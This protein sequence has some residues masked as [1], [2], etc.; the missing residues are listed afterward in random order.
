MFK[1]TISLV[2]FCISIL[3]AG[4]KVPV[5]DLVYNDR[6]WFYKESNV[7]F[8]G[9]AFSI[10]K[11]TGTII[12]Q[13]NYIDGLAWGKYYEW[14]PNGSKKVNGTY[15]FGLMY[16]R[17]K[18][19]YESGKILCAGS[20][21]NG[22]GHN[23]TDLINNIPQDGI[24]GLWTYW[25]ND[26]R[27]VEEGYYSKNGMEKGNWAFWDRDGKK[28]I[29]K[30]IDYNTFKNIG[31]FKHLDGVFLVTGPLDGLTTVYTQAHGA[32]RSGKLDG[33]WTYW[34]NDGL[35]SAKKHYDKGIPWGQYTTYH[36]LGHKL[37][38]GIVKGLDDYRNL[39]KDGKWLFWDEQG[40]LKEEVHYKDGKREGLSTYFSI[41]GNQSAKIIYKD[42]IPWNGEWTIWYHDGTKKES[43][44]YSE[45]EKQS[46]WTAWYE[47][48]QKKYVIH[49]KNSLKHGLYTEWN[50][51]GR[52]TKDIEYNRGNPISEYLVEYQGQSY[53][54]INRRNG[55]LSGSWIKWYGNGKKCEEGVYKY[56]KKGGLWTGWH[57]NGEKKYNSK[58][59]DG[60]P[61]GLYT[62]L[63]NKG[64]LTKNIEYDQGIILSEYHISRDQS[65]ATEYHKKNGV[66]DGKWTR[67][68]SNGNKAEEG[69]YKNG[70]RSGNWNGWYRSNKKNYACIYEDGKRAGTYTEWNSKGKKI[71]EIDYSNGNRIREYVVIKDGSGF[72]EMS[73]L[74]GKLDG[75]W[76]KWYSDGKKEEEGKYKGGIK[77]GT[78]SRYSMEGAI[79][80]EW[81][82]DNKGRNLYEITYYDNGTV[83]EYRDFFSKT[84][85]EYNVDG[86]LKGDKI[87]FN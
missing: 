70:K 7:P 27:K 78:W 25:D 84:I 69:I 3:L 30:K 2:C 26:G 64:R 81:N 71:K 60:K 11:E 49:Y 51:D 56:G 34:N 63:D 4:L 32:I 38:D 24:S 35:L 45:G 13:A 42:G 80:E 77:I 79:I 8:T 36:P 33:P 41:T 22:K 28:R 44:I 62:E 55:E 74:Y 53:I 57:E 15:R 85:Q 87:P 6:L 83:K 54:E 59:I 29:G 9:V 23:S 14:W 17:W 19:F 82:F 39:I 75:A 68:Y 10:S 67:W 58:Y 16:G 86:S 61:D 72:M 50:K 20:Y 76:V 40:I 12:Q 73:K 5:S 43:G 65:G 1:K 31:S 47:N 37:A 66:L 46:P 48:G 52:L 18:F 21:M